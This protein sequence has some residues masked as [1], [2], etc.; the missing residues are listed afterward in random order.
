MVHPCRQYEKRGVLLLL[1]L[2]R[3]MRCSYTINMGTYQLAVIRHMSPSETTPHYSHEAADAN[4]SAA[5]PSGLSPLAQ[6]FKRHNT[7]RAFSR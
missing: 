2:M 1:L 3:A 5:K 4:A 6:P 7:A